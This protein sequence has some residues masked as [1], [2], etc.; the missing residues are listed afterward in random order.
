MWLEKGIIL[1]VM[2]KI[3]LG[4]MFILIITLFFFHIFNQPIHT[5]ESLSFSF[6][7]LSPATEVN[8]ALI[9]LSNNKSDI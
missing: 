7:D 9:Y 1:Q 3:C 4:A 6:E 2:Y 8:K 5:T